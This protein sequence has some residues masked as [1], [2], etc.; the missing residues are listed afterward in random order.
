MAN[1]VIWDGSA[2]FTTSSTPF[3][4]YDTDTD[5]QTDAVKVAKFCGTRLGYPLMDVELQDQNFFTCFEEA[6]TTYG[7]E[8]FQ[9]KIRENYLNLEGAQTGS[10]LN[11]R[12]IEPT[13]NRVVN[14]SKNYATEA[15]VN[16]L[17]TRH[18]GSLAVTA[19]K[20]D[21]DMDAWATDQ[22]IEGGIEIRRIF[23]EAPPAILRYFDPY[24]GTG[25]GTQSLMDAFD[26]GSFSP[27]VNFL[28]MPISYDLAKVQAIELNDQVRKS[29]YSFELVNNKLRIFPKPRA[30]YRLLFEYFKKDDKSNAF[31]NQSKGM[32][33]N[34]A[35]VPYNN[36]IYSQ[37]NSVGRQWI[38]RYTLALTKELLGYVR[39]KYQTVPVPGSE[40]TLNQAD[41]LND[42]RT[43]REKLMTEL[44]EMLEQTSRQ[45]QL[46][47]KANESENLRKTLTDV[48]YT[49]YIG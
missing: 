13:L 1:V 10:N 4:F 19:S 17:V 34:V 35:E 38:F 24:A 28:M 7:N 49:I 14:I 6:V 5:F 12:L 15:G 16:G 36:P 32:V 18:T 25:T 33:T 23:Y 30:R 2:T 40:A 3:G 46:E 41:L 29:S 20:Q 9:Y 27:G 11:N 21:Y 44:K 26:F 48:P 43:E 42:S 39:G 22:G 31:T 47:R 45:S 37:I 8:V